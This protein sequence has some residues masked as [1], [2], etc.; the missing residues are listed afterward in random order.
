MPIYEYLC[1]ACGH[2]FEITQRIT[3]D[4]ISDCPAC[5]K[6]EAQRQ[7][8]AT[9]F[10]LKGSGW[11]KTDYGNSGGANSS[12]GATT[13]GSDSATKKES[14]ETKKADPTN[15][16]DSAS[17]KSSASKTKKKAASND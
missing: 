9:A 2:Q 15:S 17:K 13:S 3:E 14:K 10:H 5:G 6:P 4:A 12:P 8:S 1:G 7:I 16:K 11:Y